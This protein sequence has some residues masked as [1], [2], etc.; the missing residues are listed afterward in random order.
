MRINSIKFPSKTILLLFKLV[1]YLI[2][3]MHF[4]N[5]PTLILQHKKDSKFQ[6]K[7]KLGIPEKTIKNRKLN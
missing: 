6:F 2:Q 5:I 7:K 4:H 1:S 3:K